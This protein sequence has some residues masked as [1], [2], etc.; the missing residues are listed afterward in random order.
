MAID[1]TTF[2]SWRQ[3]NGLSVASAVAKL[4]INPSTGAALTATDITSY[5]N[6]SKTIPDFGNLVCFVTWNLPPA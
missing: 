5:E 4:N 6:G 2:K 3:Y 1:A